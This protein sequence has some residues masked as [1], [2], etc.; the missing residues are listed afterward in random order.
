MVSARLKAFVAFKHNLNEPEE[1]L[2]IA[3]DKLQKVKPHCAL[4]TTHTK[5][6]WPAMGIR[7]KNWTS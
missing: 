3:S 6:G 4:P 2:S 5:A 7:D 1:S